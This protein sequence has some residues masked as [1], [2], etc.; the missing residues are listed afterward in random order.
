MS[1]SPPRFRL[2]A[3][4][5]FFVED[6][7]CI[8]CTA[9][10]HEA[11]ELM[12]HAKGG[13]LIYHCYFRRQPE[14]PEEVEHAIRAVFVSCCGAVQYGGSDPSILNRFEELRER[15]WGQRDV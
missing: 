1:E 9:P 2:N 4:G 3:P 12:A 15:G 7:R 10:E 13:D 14:T 6:G 5:D 8:A 11:P